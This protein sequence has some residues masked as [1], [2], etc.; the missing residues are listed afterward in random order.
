MFKPRIIACDRCG[1]L[2]LQGDG[3]CRYCRHPTHG[4]RRAG[5]AKAIGIGI[6]LAATSWLVVSCAG[7]SG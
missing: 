3:Y 7:V 2:L 6:A 4:K 5:L 1:Q